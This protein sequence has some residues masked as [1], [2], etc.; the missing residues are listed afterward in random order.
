MPTAHSFSEPLP[1]PPPESWISL[2]F[3]ISFW[4]LAQEPASQGKKQEYALQWAQYIKEHYPLLINGLYN[5]YLEQQR[6]D[7]QK[8]IDATLLLDFLQYAQERHVVLRNVRISL[9]NKKITLFLSLPRALDALYK[10]PVI[11]DPSQIT[12]DL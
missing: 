3:L 9:E 8:L 11:A 12:L 1:S 6:L 10:L 4:G 5:L 7:T 2:D